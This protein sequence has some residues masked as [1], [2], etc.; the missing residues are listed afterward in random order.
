METNIVVKECSQKSQFIF[1]SYNCDT[2]LRTGD[3]LRYVGSKLFYCR[4]DVSG[5]K[6]LGVFFGVN[7]RN[8]SFLVLEFC[9]D[10]IKQN[11]I[12]CDINNVPNFN[13][14]TFEYVKNISIEY[15]I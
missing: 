3:L 15:T 9:H 13:Y 4:T 7:L 8:A 11:E 1:P 6:I 10:N 12:F 2:F 14:G 5:V